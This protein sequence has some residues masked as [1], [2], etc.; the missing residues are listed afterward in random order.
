MKTL[1]PFQADIV[2][3]FHETAAHARRIL[4]VSPTGSGKTVIGTDIIKEYVDRGQKVMFV[5]HRRELVF[6]ALAE[7]KAAGLW[8]GVIMA[9]EA[10]VPLAPVQVAMVQTLHARAIRGHRLELPE[11]D[12][13]L[14]V[15]DE[16]HHAAAK[17]WPKVTKH[18]V[19]AARRARR[20][21]SRHA[22]SSSWLRTLCRRSSPNI[23]V[24]SRMS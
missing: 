14:V 19:A 22:A 8:C 9:G 18:P 17:S 10:S 2:R 6:Q 13:G 7:L 24:G 20:T 16:C 5:V 4:I 21:S 11:I 3:R 23:R 12:D 15:V 1:H